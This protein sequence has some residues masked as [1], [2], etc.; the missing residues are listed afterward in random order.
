MDYLDNINN[1]YLMD[2]V[3]DFNIIPKQVIAVWD[4]IITNYKDT[5]FR[6]YIQ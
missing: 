1:S 4:L 6:T 3:T 5:V 2:I